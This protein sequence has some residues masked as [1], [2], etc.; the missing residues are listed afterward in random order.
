LALLAVIVQFQRFFELILWQLMAA[1]Q[2]E[3]RP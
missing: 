3:M 2:V 1:F